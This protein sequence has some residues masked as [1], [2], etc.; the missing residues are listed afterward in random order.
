[1]K[2]LPSRRCCRRPGVSTD[3]RLRQPVDD[4]WLK[5]PES[6]DGDN[7]DH[8]FKPK[9]TLCVLCCIRTQRNATNLMNRLTHIAT[10]RPTYGQ[11]QHVRGYT[12]ENTQSSMMLK[13]KMSQLRKLYYYTVYLL[14]LRRF[15]DSSVFVSAKESAW[16][17][18]SRISTDMCASRSI[19][20]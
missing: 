11:T 3:A 10:H 2:L 4:G 1:M 19:F 14:S 12:L 8:S 15:L 17:S 9:P 16:S 7:R 5:S 18:S 13:E 20:V 6:G